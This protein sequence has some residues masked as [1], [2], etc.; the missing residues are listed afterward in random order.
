MVSNAELHKLITNFQ[1][2][3]NQRCDDLTNAGNEGRRKLSE[4][5]D[6][7]SE[8]L[9]TVD[10]RLD[11]IEENQQV[12]TRK[13]DEI[14]HSNEATK[15]VTD[16]HEERIL[17]LERRL[18]AEEKQY[19]GEFRQLGEDNDKLRE[20]IENATN[21]Q[22]RRTLIIRNIPETKDE[23]SY[24]E[25]KELLARTIGLNTDMSYEEV[26]AGI[27]RAH[28][29]P[30]RDGGTREGKRNIFAAFTTWEL[31]QKII[32]QVRQ[33]CINDRTFEITADQ[34]YGP[35]TTRRRNLAYQVRE[36]SGARY[37]LWWVC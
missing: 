21:R 33:R 34:M 15:K 5:L 12:Y 10:L 37:G 22:S 4:K 26:F 6:A 14:K 19:A 20:E 7:F 1:D 3:F 35:L 36:V 32:E 9:D 24:P 25:V 31:S 30:K 17:D 2:Q 29:E 11:K 16:D 27:D 8:R 23:E 18:L 28:R 13:F